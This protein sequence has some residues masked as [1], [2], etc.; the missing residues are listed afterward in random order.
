MICPN[1]KKEIE[2]DRYICPHCG[3]LVS[4]HNIEMPVF[5]TPIYGDE[6]DDAPILTIDA[7][8]N[9]YEER[10]SFSN[11]K[12]IEPKNDVYVNDNYTV[13]YSVKHAVEPKTEYQDFTLEDSLENASTPEII[14]SDILLQ[15]F[16]NVSEEKEVV[17]PVEINEPSKDIKPVE[18]TNLPPN[19][20]DVSFNEMPISDQFLY[21]KKGIIPNQDKVVALDQQTV[22]SI[23]EIPKQNVE[24]IDKPASDAPLSE[25]TKEPEVIV[26]MPEHPRGKLPSEVHEETKKYTGLLVLAIIF[27]VLAG[28]VFSYYLFLATKSPTQYQL[29]DEVIPSITSIVGNRS[30]KDTKVENNNDEIKK[31]YN[32]NNISNVTADLTNYI[33]YL[34][35]TLSF[36]NTTTYDLTESSGTIQLGNEGKTE[37]YVVLITITYNNNSYSIV[38]ERKLGTL[39]RY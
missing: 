16:N 6:K 7:S 18:E 27:L 34:T 5:E 13:D 14:D 11:P 32:Y 22:G 24:I 37:G 28:S 29:K 19:T 20:N 10:I 38:V 1:C 25:Y 31:T 15:P 23:S 36:I 3:S 35:E 9:D 26:H 4:S 2:Q 17:P 30:V 21:E 33:T 12:P 39:T 8:P